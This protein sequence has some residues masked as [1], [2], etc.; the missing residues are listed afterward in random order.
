MTMEWNLIVEAG[1]LVWFC[2]IITKNKLPKLNHLLFYKQ[3]IYLPLNRNIA[4]KHD[5]PFLCIV[6]FLSSSVMYDF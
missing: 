4:V 2:D 6:D 5:G 3:N 1:V